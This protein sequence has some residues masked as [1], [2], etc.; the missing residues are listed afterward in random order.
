[1]I[2][3]T[4]CKEIRDKEKVWN[5]V[6]DIRRI[7]EFWKGT[8]ELNVVEVEHG[9][10]EGEIKFAFPSKG[11]VRIEVLENKV[12]INYLKGPVLG[13]HEIYIEGDKICSSWNVKLSFPFNLREKWTAEH[14]KSGAVHAL[15]RIV[16]S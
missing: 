2:S 4:V 8:R 10:Y 5:I 15:E 1:M 16:E 6:K 3:F 13:K 14:F 7:P 11:K 9:V 12:V